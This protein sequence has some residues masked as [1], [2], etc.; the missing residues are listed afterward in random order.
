[1]R[2][3]KVKN[4]EKRLEEYAAYSVK[5][6]KAMKGK[7]NTVFENE[8]ELYLELGCGK[9]QFLLKQAEH[10]PNAN[11]IGIEAQETIILRALEKADKSNIGNIRFVQAFMQ[12]VTE[13][14][15]E[16]ELSG[17]FLN[18]SDPWPKE[19]H[20]KRRLT[21]TKFLKGYEKILKPDAFIE[22][23]TD[24]DQL[25]EF[26]LEEIQQN[27]YKIVFCSKDLHQS[28]LAAKYITTE[29]EDKF[30]TIGK[31]INYVRFKV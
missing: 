4:V 26:T 8:K 6:G 11:F 22:F 16:E 13:F 2:Q 27:E 12:D 15:E 5:D 19:R 18:F 28:D 21:H 3:R 10:N 20:A 30:K 14:F 24:N 9:G 7:W 29:Y 31:N 25:F 23:K 1:M 17:L